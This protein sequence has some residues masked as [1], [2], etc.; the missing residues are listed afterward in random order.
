MSPDAMWLL[1]QSNPI[2]PPIQ[3][4]PSLLWWIY[5]FWHWTQCMVCQYHLH[6]QPRR[7][8]THY[9][10]DVNTLTKSSGP[11]WGIPG[12][13]QI[14]LNSHVNTT[15]NWVCCSKIAWR[16]W[17]CYTKNPLLMGLWLMY[18][19]LSSS[20]A[21]SSPFT[22]FVVWQHR[23]SKCCPPCAV[24]SPIPWVVWVP[25]RHDVRPSQT[26]YLDSPLGCC[27]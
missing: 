7:A 19:T 5:Q 16:G 14:S 1:A 9:G 21:D 20:F 10:F 18:T 27:T 23:F 15:W 2:P 12:Q 25:S 24:Q 26:S 8:V 11:H 3:S 17:V 4:T 13:L 6:Q 22:V